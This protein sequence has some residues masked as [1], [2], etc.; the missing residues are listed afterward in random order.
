MADQG[1]LPTNRRRR[2]D[3][4][5]HA[6]R[7]GALTLAL[8]LAGPAAGQAAADTRVVLHLPTGDRTL[9]DEDLRDVDVVSQD[10][11]LRSPD[12]EETETL[13]GLSISRALE[14]VG[15]APGEGFVH[16]ER[17]DE[18]WAMLSA[19]DVGD[20]SPFQDGLKPLI[21]LDSVRTHYFRPVRNGTDVNAPDNLQSDDNQPLEVW[22]RAGAPLTVTATASRSDASKGD[23]V[24]F[25]ATVSGQ[26]DGESVTVRWRFDDG[27]TAEG[28][29]ALHSFDADG[30]YGV[31]AVAEGDQDSGG[32]SDV[33]RI[34][35]GT[36]QGSGPGDGA[37]TNTGPAPTTGPS[38]GPATGTGKSKS[39]RKTNRNSGDDRSASDDTTRKPS[40][41]ATP[42]PAAT[43][44]A[45]T[46]AVPPAPSGTGSIPG[47]GTFSP[48]PPG[49]QRIPKPLS[50][51]ATEEGDL[52]RG[53]LVSASAPLAVP[54][55]SA[56]R[57]GARAAAQAGAAATPLS[58]SG[59]TALLL[60]AGGAWR[61]GAGRRSRRPA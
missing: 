36:P 17:K 40:V 2:R 60:L 16:F 21:L 50:P 6:I 39:K 58:L 27:A 57:A 29:S 3:E 54:A 15:Y 53:V 45:P 8:L 44:A 10:Y 41:T 23:A 20:P 33:V 49:S 52:V 56:S 25:A 31:V 5:I 7:L 43:G 37:G 55:A 18:T 1:P 12:S 30:V 59:L 46:S 28:S 61:E 48:Q 14:K 19:D 42:A 51:A 26:R 32:A 22:A 35:V 13:T 47:S 38:Q 34:R 4:L 24:A 11:V 9:T